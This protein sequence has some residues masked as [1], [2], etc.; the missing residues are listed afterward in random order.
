[1]KTHILSLLVLFLAQFELVFL[2]PIKYPLTLGA[3]N[4]NTSIHDILVLPDFNIIILGFSND[5]SLVSI[6]LATAV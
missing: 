4:G 3:F 5:I 2:A 1:M 6:D